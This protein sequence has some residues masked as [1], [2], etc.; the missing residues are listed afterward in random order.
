[1]I[2]IPPLWNMTWFIDMDLLLRIARLHLQSRFSWLLD[3]HHWQ[4]QI[5]ESEAQIE[6]ADRDPW[7]LEVPSDQTSKACAETGLVR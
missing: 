3:A 2:H 7:T 4:E 5:Q 1:M 6:L